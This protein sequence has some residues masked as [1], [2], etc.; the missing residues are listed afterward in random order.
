[1]E[2]EESRALACNC[3]A[4]YDNNIISG[5][6]FC[7]LKTQID[8]PCS[9]FVLVIQRHLWSRPDL[10]VLDELRKVNQKLSNPLLHTTQQC[11]ARLLAVLVA[12]GVT[13]SRRF[14]CGAVTSSVSH[15]NLTMAV[16]PACCASRP[17]QPSNQ[18]SSKKKKESSA[19]LTQAARAHTHTYALPQA[20]VHTV[21]WKF[22]GLTYLFSW[23]RWKQIIYYGLFYVT[24][25]WKQLTIL[26]YQK[27][28]EQTLDLLSFNQKFMTSV[29]AQKPAISIYDINLLQHKECNCCGHNGF[30]SPLHAPP[31]SSSHSGLS[32]CRS[33]HRTCHTQ[34]REYLP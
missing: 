28:A 13:K 10:A 8:C 33:C 9:L 22:I 26:V 15:T 19:W 32:R 27:V 25:R 4:W 18:K 30:S 7:P 17:K 29:R 5:N 12:Q 20:H 3:P 21:A 14:M 31:A 23:F 34:R 11:I 24:L 2:V 6:Q 16:C 1:M